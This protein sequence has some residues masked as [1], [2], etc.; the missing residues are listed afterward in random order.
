MYNLGQKKNIG[1]PKY[2]CDTCFWEQDNQQCKHPQEGTRAFKK[3]TERDCWK[4]NGR[5]SIATSNSNKRK[6]RN[7]AF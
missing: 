3:L 7:G 5:K 4:F 1:Q 6:K 2:V